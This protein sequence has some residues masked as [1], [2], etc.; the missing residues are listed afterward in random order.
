MELALNIIYTQ[1]YKQKQ[2]AAKTFL[3][4]GVCTASVHV[5]S[6]VHRVTDRQTGGLL[7]GVEFHKLAHLTSKRILWRENKSHG[8]NTDYY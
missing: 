3:S 8:C 7:T 4:H 2:S 1:C 5:G 6:G